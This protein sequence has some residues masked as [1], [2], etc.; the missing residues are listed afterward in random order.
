MRPE[1]Y[2]S[3]GGREAERCPLCADEGLEVILGESGPVKIVRGASVL[4][5]DADLG[6]KGCGMYD[7]MNPVGSYEIIIE[8]TGHDTPAEEM[9]PD[10]FKRVLDIYVERLAELIKDP[11]VRYVFIYK[12]S[13]RAAGAVTAHPHSELLATP[14][15]PG[16]VKYELDGAKEYFSYKERCV[17]CDIL[18]EEE[19]AGQRIIA[20]T[21]HF[22]AFCPYASR[23]PF[24]FWIMP[25]VHSCSFEEITGAELQDLASLMPSLV[26]K[27][28]K[29]LG[30]PPYN[31]YIHTAPN[32]IPRRN[33]WHTLGDDFHWHIEV[34][35]VL[36]RPTAIDWGSGFHILTTS[37]EDAAKYIKEAQ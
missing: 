14:V 10:Y 1:D 4:V 30:D 8:N 15:I 20:S 9:G 31:Y 12:N 32:R 35:P 13:G 34:L 3:L 6:R 5:K 11:G 23:M 25:K 37:P 17:F 26:L 21:E 27:M 24:E 33:H 2:L 29:A 22:T 7:R 16:T 18:A 19:R 36:S 28:R